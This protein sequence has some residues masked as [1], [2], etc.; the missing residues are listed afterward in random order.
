MMLRPASSANSPAIFLSDDDSVL[1]RERYGWGAAIPGAGCAMRHAARHARCHA[2]DAAW[3]RQR[4]GEARRRRPADLVDDLVDV[5]EQRRRDAFDHAYRADTDAPRRRSSRRSPPDGPT[6]PPRP[7]SARGAIRRSR[8]RSQACARRRA[9]LQSPDDARR[10]VA[11]LRSGRSQTPA[12][13]ARRPAAPTIIA[14]PTAVRHRSIRPPTS[15]RRTSMAERGRIA[16]ITTISSRSRTARWTLRPVN[17]ASSIETAARGR[18]YR[19]YARNPLLS[20]STEAVSTKRSLS[21][22]RNSRPVLT[23]VAAMRETGGW[24]GDAGPFGQF[25]IAHRRVGASD[26]AQNVQSARNA[27]TSSPSFSLPFSRPE[28]R[29]SGLFIVFLKYSFVWGSESLDDTRTLFPT[30][31]GMRSLTKGADAATLFHFRALQ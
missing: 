25:A 18:E 3:P 7:R 11:G 19:S 13:A 23:S 1:H 8:S 4:F 29:L 14:R 9:R 16:S 5:A 22:S 31:Q 26:A 6:N 10:V 12:F 2:M 28:G 27:V 20:S 21:G 15:R 24:F 30:L 17:S